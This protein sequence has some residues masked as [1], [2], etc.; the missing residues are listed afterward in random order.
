VAARGLIGF[1]SE[2]WTRDGR[3]AASGS[4][5]LITRAVPAS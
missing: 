2:V 4:G 1:R 5:Q 3:L